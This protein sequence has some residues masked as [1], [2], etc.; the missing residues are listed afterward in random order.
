[1]VRRGKLIAAQASAAIE[2]EMFLGE[3]PRLLLT[4]EL[5]SIPVNFSKV[6]IERELSGWR[7]GVSTQFPGVALDSISADQP[8]EPGPVNLMPAA[9]TQERWQERRSARLR[10]RLLL[11]GAIYLFLL[12]LAAGYIIWLQR[13]VGMVNAQAQAT[14]PAVDAIATRKGRWIALS[15][16]DRSHP[17]PGRD[18]AAGRTE[19]FRPTPCA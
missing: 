11:A 9:W 18:P 3:L 15:A 17:L 4:L 10:Q 2:R 5:E 1:M 12:L 13:Q 6:F 8:L 19:A 16:R 14:A 7:D